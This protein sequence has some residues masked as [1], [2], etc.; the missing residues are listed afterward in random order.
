[1]SE[2]DQNPQPEPV[3]HTT[4]AAVSND[5]LNLAMLSHLLCILL[6]F[7]A[8]L[9]IWLMNKDNAAKGFVNDQAKE[10]LNFQITLIIGYV[11]SFILS[12]VVIGV[13]LTLILLLANLVLCIIAALAAKKGEAY[14]YLLT[15]RL[16][17]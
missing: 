16:V 11:I 1:M 3:V 12:F 6:G 5:D 13:F 17:K 14:R 7:L 8:P 15:L 10:S 4:S 9:I 2:H